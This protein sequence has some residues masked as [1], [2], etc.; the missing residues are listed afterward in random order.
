VNGSGNTLSVTGTLSYEH[1]GLNGEFNAVLGRT[2]TLSVSNGS[3]KLQ[4]PANTF[5][6]CVLVSGGAT[7][8][9]KSLGSG[10]TVR[11][12]GGGTLWHDA[13]L[14]NAVTFDGGKWCT[15]RSRT[16][17]SAVTLAGDAT[18]V[19]GGG[20]ELRAGLADPARR[21]QL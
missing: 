10:A 21:Q 2:G 3:L 17:T 18:F 7:L 13:D 4:N 5:S 20:L 6:G 14:A 16:V 12:S 8:Q 11:V 19:S 9:V 1:P 15:G